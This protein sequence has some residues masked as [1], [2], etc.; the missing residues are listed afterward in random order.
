MHETLIYPVHKMKIMLL[1]L[2]LQIQYQQK[3]FFPVLYQFNSKVV[4]MDIFFKEEAAP[5]TDKVA[6]EVVSIVE[7][8]RYASLDLP[9]ICNF[10]RNSRV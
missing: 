7:L 1:T 2:H 5:C 8:N 10:F 6:E 3:G 4:V 9:P